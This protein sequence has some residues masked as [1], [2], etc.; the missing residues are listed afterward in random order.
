M[1]ELC[2]TPGQVII[3]GVRNFGFEIIKEKHHL[4]ESNG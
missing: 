3:K 1:G 2:G 4:L